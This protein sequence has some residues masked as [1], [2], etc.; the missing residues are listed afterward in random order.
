MG[1]GARPRRRGRAAAVLRNRRLRKLRRGRD[2]SQVATQSAPPLR[3]G[4]SPERNAAESL[5]R[6]IFGFRSLH[7]WRSGRLRPLDRVSSSAFTAVRAGQAINFCPH[8]RR[9][10][11]STPPPVR[12][13]VLN[14]YIASQCYWV[15]ASVAPVP[16]READTPLVNWV[17]CSPPGPISVG[18]Y[19]RYA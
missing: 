15:F 7:M 6:A 19:M 5:T 13:R 9:A 11:E 4:T 12:N 3:H 8:H 2:L 14:R 17:A 1:L 16:T 18:R 10:S